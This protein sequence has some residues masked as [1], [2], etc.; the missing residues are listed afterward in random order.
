MDRAG[1]A[2]KGVLSKV[3]ASASAGI[4]MERALNRTPTVVRNL[5]RPSVVREDIGYRQLSHE[6]TLTDRQP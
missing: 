6:G 4:I 2:G 1:V 5:Y 3:N